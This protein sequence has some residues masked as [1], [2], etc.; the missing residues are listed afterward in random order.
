MRELAPR[1]ALVEALAPLRPA[2]GGAGEVW[3]VGGAVRDALLGRPVLDFD[4]VVRGDAER[5][6]RAYARASGGAP[7]ALSERHG[8]WRVVHG[9]R[10]LDVT[11]FADTLPS[12]LGRRDFTVDAIAVRLNDGAVVDPLDGVADLAAG[13][14]RPVSDHI[15]ADDPLRLL[16]LV[17]LASEL[18]LALTPEAE[19]LARRDAAL[20]ARAAGERQLA[21]LLRLLAAPDPVEGLHVLEDL[22]ILAAVLPEVAALRGVEQNPYHHLDVLD[23]TLHVVDAVADV[24]ENVGH[25]LAPP[26]AA[27]VEAELAGALDGSVGVRLALRLAA[28]LHDVAKPETRT[29]TADGQIKFFGHEERGAEITHGIARRLHGSRALER[30]LCVLVRHHLALGFLVKRR[31]LTPRAAYRYAV[32]TAPHPY[33]AIVLSLGDRLATRGVRSRLRGVR[34]HVELASEMAAAVARLG[35]LPPPALLPA[36]ELGRRAGMQPGPALGALVAALRE[37]QAAGEVRTADDA[38]AFA[39]A[40]AERMERGA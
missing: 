31:P 26:A 28:L 7:F 38:V 25:Y 22:G 40:F 10:T 8:A 5:L 23:H 13:V 35:P 39:R 34:R 30:F 4:V 2:L 9:E 3:V 11:S 21:E 33:A 24:S 16:R 6:A 12:D 1:A 15:F 37:E 36:D 19:R 27:P 18:D 20:A 32:A 14:L 29:V 17:R